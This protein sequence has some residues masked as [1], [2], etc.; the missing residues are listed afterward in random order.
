MLHCFE[1]RERNSAG[2]WFE[3]DGKVYVSLPGVPFEM[4]A[5]MTGGPAASGRQ[6]RPDHPA[7]HHPD[8]R[9]GRI[10]PGSQI[11]AWENNLPAFIKLAYLPQPGIVRLR[12]TATGTDEFLLRK[13]V[14]RAEEEL[15]ILAGEHIFGFDEDTLEE[16]IGNLLRE[17]H[18]TLATP[19]AVPAGWW[20]DDH[21]R[22]RQQRLLPGKRRCLL[23]RSEGKGPRVNRL[24]IQD[25]GAVSEETVREM[26]EGVRSLLG[27]GYAIAISGIAGPGGG[28]EEKPVGTTWIAVA[29][30][31][32]TVAAHFRFGEHRG[33]NIQRAALAALS[34]LRKELLHFSS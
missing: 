28:S 3:K 8:R 26:A 32:R 4:K 24:T 33:R 20:P 30:G 16:V 17:R 10:V 1:Q 21:L 18:Q 12:L 15:M 2:M 11:E 34:M 14:T 25:H 27:T 29:S 31:Q 6:E 23:Q 13:A 7:P 22:C 5:L 19:K 9:R